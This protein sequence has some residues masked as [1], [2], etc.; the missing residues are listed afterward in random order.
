MMDK[1]FV[2]KW[3]PE[4]DRIEG[5]DP[6]YAE[7]VRTLRKEIASKGTISK[8]TFKQLY[9]WKAAR[10]R[11]S[12]HWDQFRPYQRMIGQAAIK[13]RKNAD[14][15]TEDVI[16]SLDELPGV[17]VP[18]AST[19]AHFLSPRKMPVVDF[20]TVQ[21]LKDMG[22]LNRK[23]SDHYFKGTYEG[24]GI[25]RTVMLGLAKKHTKGSLRVLDKAL[26]A[27]HKAELGQDSKHRRRK[28][29][30]VGK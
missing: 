7:I 20:R 14:N 21:V 12:I 30:Q 2:T 10:A 6:D 4:Y 23:K 16:E 18:V 25:F 22:Y 5:D 11:R 29:C 13:I 9:N 28:R 26:F 1:A 19:I 17:G 24:Y 27:Y 8:R 15:N 3:E